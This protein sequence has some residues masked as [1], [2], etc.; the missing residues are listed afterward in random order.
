[1]NR[2]KTL[3]LLAMTALLA[4]SCI[5]D[6][7][8]CSTCG[9][10]PEGRGI[11]LSFNAGTDTRSTLQSSEVDY[12]DVYRVF[13]YVFEGNTTDAKC[14]HSQDIGWVNEDK[15]KNVEELM[16]QSFWIDFA[17]PKDKTITFLAVG[18][19]DR[20]GEVY[21]FNGEHDGS[22]TLGTLMAQ[23]AT[24]K[25][26][27]DMA[28][29]QF[30][31]GY[32]SQ[33]VGQEEDVV[34]VE[35]TLTRKVAGVLAYLGNIP[36]KVDYTDANLGQADVTGIRLVLG[37]S[38][39]TQMNV[40]SASTD[41]TPVYGGE[42]MEDTDD[43]KILFDYNL[44]ELGFTPDEDDRYFTK[45]AQTNEDGVAITLPNTL[46]YGAYLLPLNMSQGS[47]TL[48]L[49]LIGSYTTGEGDKHYNE[50]VKTYIIQNSN[51]ETTFPLNENYFYSIGKKLSDNSTDNDKPADLSGNV[52]EIAVTAWHEHT[53]PNNFP[54]VTAPA[55]VMSAESINPNNY[56]FDAPGTTTKVTVLP[57]TPTAKSW[58]MTINYELEE[59]APNYSLNKDQKGWIHIKEYDATG[60]FTGYVS[61]LTSSDG[62]ERTVELVL[63][64]FAVQ[65]DLKEKDGDY[66]YTDED[67]KMAKNDYRTAYIE[68][69]TAGQ[70]STP[71]RMRIRQYNTLTIRSS[72]NSENMWIGT[73]RLDYGCKFD[74][75]TGE[76]IC[77][78]TSTGN[79][80]E[81][82][83]TLN[84]W[85]YTSSGTIVISGD[86]GDMDSKD[87]ELNM[88][89]TMAHTWGFKYFEG[90]LMWK[91]RKEI[92]NIKENQE[93]EEEHTWY[94]PAYQEMANLGN[95][96]TP[97]YDSPECIKLFNM[98]W[99]DKY[100]WTST[101]KVSM[102]GIDYETYYVDLTR[103][104]LHKSEARSEYL[105]KPRDFDPFGQTGLPPLATI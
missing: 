94:L 91:V 33:E 15:D 24:G 84:H 86:A 23:L 65:R 22:L 14:I 19:D 93:Q 95:Y 36:C 48:Q 26:K 96:V 63:N 79:H 104:N 88:T 59:D 99:S 92:I 60:K 32:V 10:N 47:T 43:N 31:S 20:A 85:G 74:P 101:G 55:R 61:E 46:L 52:L 54:N 42:P 58:T 72:T 75:E 4:A 57:A 69:K 45:Q 90:S 25:G 28:Q 102:N 51:G 11:L 87:G 98:G 49:Q 80:N 97:G 7:P 77:Q 8:T 17:V 40:W 39:N 6:E 76:A 62:G 68:I 89:K 100:Y 35:I 13:L 44:S 66:K 12:K 27:D 38:Q 37:A 2:I 29:A 21:G 16:T 41:E 81:R 5:K 64:D 50:V 18:V 78:E 1:M 3:T 105:E 103:K 83:N 53:I 34:D 56:I 9:D 82:G 71:Y 30:F 73:S 67:I 70:E